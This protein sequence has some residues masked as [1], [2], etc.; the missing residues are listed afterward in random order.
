MAGVAIPEQHQVVAG[1]P[2][3]VV[4]DAKNPEVAG[5]FIDYLVS[6]EGQRILADFGFSKP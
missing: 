6:P 5:R 4:K 2:I 3:A 1:Y